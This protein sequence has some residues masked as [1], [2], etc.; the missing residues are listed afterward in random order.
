VKN[1]RL[2]LQH[3]I[4]YGF[5]RNLIWGL[6]IMII[7]GSLWLYLLKINKFLSGFY[8]ML[9]FL[10]CWLIILLLSKWL[11]NRYWEQYAKVLFQEYLWE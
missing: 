11:M 9:W 1:G 3:N 6:P 8:I 7:V 5:R 4:E 10:I 2:L